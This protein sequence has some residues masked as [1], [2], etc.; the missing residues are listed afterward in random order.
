MNKHLFLLLA[1]FII[2][3]LG[4]IFIV[5]HSAAFGLVILCIGLLCYIFWNSFSNCEQFSIKNEI[6][7]K[8][9]KKLFLIFLI[10][11]LFFLL[12]I[13]SYFKVRSAVFLSASIQTGVICLIPIYYLFIRKDS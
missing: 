2:M 10:F 7:K 3:Y 9:F 8:H 1:S 13:S 4:I 6:G 12:A 11:S 5:F